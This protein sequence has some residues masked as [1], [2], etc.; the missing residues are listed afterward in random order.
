MLDM[1]G[2]DAPISVSGTPT[3][4]QSSEGVLTWEGNKL[5]ARRHSEGLFMIFR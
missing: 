2:A 4:V 3:I 5:Y 1:S